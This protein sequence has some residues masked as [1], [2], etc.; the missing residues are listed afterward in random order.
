MPASGSA[1]TFTLRNKCVAPTQK[2]GDG[3]K[4]L[5]LLM[6]TDDRFSR[7]GS[8]TSMSFNDVCTRWDGPHTCTAV[9]LKPSLGTTRVFTIVEELA[10]QDFSKKHGLQILPTPEV[11][12]VLHVLLNH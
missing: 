9:Y 1:T 6:R 4:L 2:I 10:T 11:V 8:T 5:F 3:L 12:Y 7:V